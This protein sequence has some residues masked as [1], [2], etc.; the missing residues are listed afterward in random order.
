MTVGLVSHPD[1][2]L[3]LPGGEHP[4]SPER[5]ASVRDHLISLRLLD[6]LK[7]Y[8]A[9]LVTREQL[10]RVHAAEYLD[11]LERKAP[12][13]GTLALDPD[14]W[15]SPA[16]LPAARRAAGAA[17]HAV[18]LV[19]AGELKSAFCNTR[20]PGHHAERARAMGFCFYNNVAVAAAHAL[21]V[22][23]LKRVAIV[24]FDT[25]WGNGT[26]D[27][28]KA[29]KRVHIFATFED[30]LFPNADVPSLPGRIHN[31][32]LP[33]GTRGREMREIYDEQLL[34]ALDAMKPQMVFISAGFDAHREDEISHMLFSEDD[35]A[36]LTDRLVDIAEKHAKGR[37]VS[38]LEGG[39]SI[40]ALGRSAAAHVKSLMKE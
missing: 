7:E 33:P 17:V 37:I 38:V 3:H 20:P 35:Y 4:E 16:T 12:A 31:V 8:D 34:P 39:Y 9:P 6:L 5:I 2:E 32:A 18:D 28:F 10:E 30:R 26:D 11:F 25:H 27:I 1:C 22:H 40:S 23:K 13:E 15:M 24:D 21:E 29:E 36:W 14:T 19:M